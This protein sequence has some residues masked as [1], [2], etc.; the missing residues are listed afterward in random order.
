MYRIIFFFLNYA[1]CVIYPGL[2][3]GCHWSEAF[4]LYRFLACGLLCG[5]YLLAIK[6]AYFLVMTNHL[7]SQ[8]TVSPVRIQ[9]RFQSGT[10]AKKKI[11]WVPV[12]LELTTLWMQVKTDAY[13]WRS[14]EC[15]LPVVMFLLVKKGS[16]ALAH[17]NK[18][19]SFFLPWKSMR[20]CRLTIEFLITFGLIVWRKS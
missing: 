18:A 16:H 8:M 10:V 1:P 7:P 5:D 4:A 15:V 3:T 9:I 19:W 17:M 12:T 20:N 11:K 6:D 13:H 14:E 2:T